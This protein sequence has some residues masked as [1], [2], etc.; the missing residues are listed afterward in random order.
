MKLPFKAMSRGVICV[1]ENLLDLV[2]ELQK[3]NFVVQSIPAGTKDEFIIEIIIPGKKFVT[4]NS[5]D[6][7]RDVSSYEIGLI[8]VEKVSKDPKT[9]AKIISDAWIDFK[10]KNKH[11]FQLILHQNGKHKFK[12]FD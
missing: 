6:F 11:G 9:L 5:K 10:L 12:Q 2:P 1:D 4:N 3:R 7:V 8:S